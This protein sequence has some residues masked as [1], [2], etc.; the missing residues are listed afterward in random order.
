MRA[1]LAN[2]TKVLRSTAGG[3]KRVHH[4]LNGLRAITLCCTAN[5]DINRRFTMSASPIG[6]WSAVSIVFVTGEAG[7]ETDCVQNC[8]EEHD[9]GRDS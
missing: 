8:A 4:R 9:V 1:R 6:T 3:T 7:Y 2:S 5:S